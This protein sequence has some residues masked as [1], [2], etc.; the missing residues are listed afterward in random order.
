MAAAAELTLLEKSLGLSKGNKYSAQGER[1]VRSGG[2]AER[3]RGTGARPGRAGPGGGGCGAR[4]L[5]G[6]SS[7][8]CAPSLLRPWLPEGVEG[9][10][11]MLRLPRTFPPAK[12]SSS[13]SGK[14][15]D[16]SESSRVPALGRRGG[17]GGPQR[18]LGFPLWEREGVLREQTGCGVHR[19]R[20]G[21]TAVVEAAVPLPSPPEAWFSAEWTHIAA[22][23]VTVLKSA[24]LRRGR[25]Q[26]LLVESCS[27]V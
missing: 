17:G 6:F 21:G 12:L 20:P 22:I 25:P 26:D 14:A 4:M 27:K 23:L 2:G 18:A 19:A 3:E 16:S 11:G 7:R 10:R 8:V 5:P 1:Q 24:A 9:A 13:R 15:R